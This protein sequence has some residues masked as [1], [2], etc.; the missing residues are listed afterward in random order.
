MIKEDDGIYRSPLSTVL[1]L[2]VTSG[3]TSYDLA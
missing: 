3:V 1:N 2:H